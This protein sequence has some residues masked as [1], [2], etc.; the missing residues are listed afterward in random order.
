MALPVFD[1]WWNYNDPAGTESKF[2]DLLPQAESSGD[3]GYH[4]ELLTQIARTLGLQQQFDAA[5]TVLDQVEPML[6][7]DLKRAR[8]RYLLERGRAFNS[9]GKPDQAKPLFIDAWELGKA[10]G[11][12]N[13]A[14]DAAHMV[15]IVES[16]QVALDWNLNAM[17]HAEA[18]DD[19]NAQ[20][21]VGSLYN[22]I[23]WAYHDMG[24]Y[25]EALAIFNKA[26]GWYELTE[27]DH[28]LRIAHWTVARTLR[29]L[30]RIDEA[31]AIHQAQLAEYEKL[32]EKPGY[33]YEELGECLLLLGRAAE[34]K[35]Y[36]ALAYEVLSQDSWL[37]RNESERLAR[38]KQLGGT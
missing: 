27:Q 20:K 30:G 12:D 14:V 23:G 11:E 34:A 22:N 28:F 29:S 33:T 16:G 31:F 13:L 4:A 25:E 10:S 38:L 26:V 37:Q 21:W 8:V 15:A 36:F 24:Q 35:P 5:H 3:V 32:G 1:N 17:R 18:S 7:P 19:P 2:R 6:T 9:S